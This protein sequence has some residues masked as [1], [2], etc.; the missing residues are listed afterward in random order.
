MTDISL[1]ML[2]GL[3]GTEVLFAPL[4]AQLPA[5]IKPIVL[6]YPASGENSYAELLEVV[7]QQVPA[8]GNFAILGSSFGG[9]LALMLAARRRSQVSAVVLCASFVRPPRPDLVKFRAIARTPVIGALRAVRRIRYVIPG[10][11]SNDLRRA[12]AVLWNRVTARLLAA[13]SRAVLGVD[14]REPLRECAAP[15]MYLAFTRD[16]VVPRANADEV[17]SIAPQTHIVEVEGSHQALFTN[18]VP[19]A[20]FIAEFLENHLSN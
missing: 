11:A 17:K 5:W 2:P 12:K 1:V 6:H 19:S 7:D 15:L 20:K 16:D 4:L 18:P 14:A 3:D 10:F 13:R 8:T 9:P